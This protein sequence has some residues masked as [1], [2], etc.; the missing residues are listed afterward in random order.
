MRRRE[1]LK[2]LACTAALPLLLPALPRGVLAATPQEQV[3]RAAPGEARLV[4][5]KYPMTRV[6]SYGG[7]VP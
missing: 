4:G 1:L 5:S 6:W 7:R 2:G 3:L